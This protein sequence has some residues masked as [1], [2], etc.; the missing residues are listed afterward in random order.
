MPGI[1]ARSATSIKD[2]P[3]HATTSRLAPSGWTKVIV[4]VRVPVIT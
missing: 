1:E 3:T 2:I 4:G